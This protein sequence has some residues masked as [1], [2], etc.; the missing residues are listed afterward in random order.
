MN[1]LPS[2]EKQFTE[3]LVE[4][5]ETNFTNEQFSVTDL[6]KEMGMSRATLHRRIKSICG[7]TV[8][9]FVNEVRLNAA[10]K[11]LEDRSGTV[12]EIAYIV[13]F[14]SSTYF[15]KCFRGHYGFSPGEVLKENYPKVNSKPE[16]KYQRNKLPSYVK[17]GG[18]LV[19]LILI[20]L[21]IFL[22]RRT[23]NRFSRESSKLPTQNQAAY[24]LYL[25]G[26]NLMEV[27]AGS[28]KKEHFLEAKNKFNAAIQRDSTFGDAYCRLAGIYFSHIPFSPQRNNSQY[29]NYVDSGRI[30][31]DKAEKFGVTNTD[32]LLKTSSIYYQH[33]INDEKALSIFEQRWDNREKTYV[34]HYERGNH[35]YF[36]REYSVTIAHLLK[37]LELKPDAIIPPYDGLMK[38]TLMF[39]SAGF[40]KEAQEFAYRQYQLSN[41][42]L[43]YWNW[44]PQI[45]FGCGNFDEAI[46]TYKTAFNNNNVGT[47][48]YNKLLEIY[49]LT[50]KKDEGLKLL[51]EYV[52]YCK[53]IYDKTI[54]NYILG[55]YYQNNDETEL[56]EWHFEEEIKRWE[57]FCSVN[58]F[59]QSL[60]N[61]L[62][63]AACYSMLND[64]DG[65]IRSL[66]KLFQKSS[67]PYL[68]VV[69]LKKSPMFDNFRQDEDFIKITGEIAD[70]YY[71]E[72]KQI[73][74]ILVRSKMNFTY[75]KEGNIVE[76]PL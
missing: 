18:P 17:I 74:N 2:M 38:L 4:V 50:G 65:V 13:G 7:K 52:A 12:S 47:T 31:L 53:T 35:G 59:Q 3:K 67:I 64:K 21:F 9:Q 49:M 39:S 75:N 22:G 70:K 56:A 76:T 58:K 8:S 6:S 37:F 57:Y 32:L 63:I 25:Q 72:Q 23:N 16:E 15:I 29:Y 42:S 68:V 73:K 19:L 45:T 26:I 20:S 41:D 34:F 51:P 24:N 55:Y 48:V 46:K 1:A 60:V 43:K 30:C 5:I 28:Q 36:M 54:P 33:I 11:L 71:T 10:K 14:G 66:E 61:Y 44:Y 27:Y 62:T 40:Q 69:R